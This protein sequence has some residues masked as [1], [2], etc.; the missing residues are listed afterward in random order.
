LVTNFIFTLTLSGKQYKL[1]GSSLGNLH[2]PTITQH[3]LLLS[4]EGGHMH[5]N[6]YNKSNIPEYQYNQWQ[7]NNASWLYPSAIWSVSSAV[8]D[9][10]RFCPPHIPKILVFT[11]TCPHF[12][13][14]FF[15]QLEI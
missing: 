9:K 3:P 7:K 2:L 12:L 1:K 14:I 15:G 6:A 5:K 11:H 13:P 4:I 10:N 8:L